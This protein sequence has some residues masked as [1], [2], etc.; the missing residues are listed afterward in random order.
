VLEVDFEQTAAFAWLTAHA[1]EFGFR[2]SYPRGNEWGF[3]YEPWHWCFDEAQ[4][5]NN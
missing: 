2:L 5:T 1:H 3:Q 4:P